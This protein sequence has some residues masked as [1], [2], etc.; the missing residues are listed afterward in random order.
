MNL[1]ISPVTPSSRRLMILLMAVVAY[2]PV[3]KLGFFW[4]DH[5]MIERNPH[6]RQWSW[7][8]LHRDFTTDAF[9][10]QGDAYYRPAQILMNRVDYSIYGLRPIGYHATNLASHAANAVLAGELAIAIG[11][12]PVAALLAGTLFAVHPI[13]VEQLMIIAGRAELMSLTWMLLSLL[14]FVRP[15]RRFRLAGVASYGV[16]LLFKESALITPLLLTLFYY[17]RQE[18]PRRY[19]DV[20][21]LV[22]FSLP[23][24]WLRHLAVGSVSTIWTPA[25]VAKFFLMAFPKILW[26]YTKLI[27]IPWNL[28][29]H[30]MIPHMSHAWPLYLALA[31]GAAAAILHTRNRRILFLAGWYVLCFLPKTPVMIYGNFTLDH[32]AYPS[33]LAVCWAIGDLLNWLIKNRDRRLA[34]CAALYFPLIIAWALI[35]PLNVALRG[36][37][38]QMYRW[39][40][41]FTTSRPIKYNLGVLLLQK[42]RAQ[43]AIPLLADV[44]RIYPENAQNT[45]ALAQAYWLCNHQQLAIRLLEELLQRDP[46]QTEAARTLRSMKKAQ[47]LK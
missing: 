47:A 41:N 38:E 4:D 21:V 25:Y 40:L 32:W 26:C 30:R 20:G 15:E 23:Y 43:E 1:N 34:A 19:L 7:A 3:L 14:A 16:A 46:T 11:L 18:K 2:A 39:A 13:G 17:L 8:E 36:S 44:Y 42:G 37:D 6:L 35:V 5:V 29:S 27:L 28:H 24:L 33:T 12:S 31:L 22:C 45:H 10:G 9:E